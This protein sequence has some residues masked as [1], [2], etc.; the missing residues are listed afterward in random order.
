IGLGNWYGGKLADRSPR[1]R[2]VQAVLFLGGVLTLG[3]WFIVKCLG[4]GTIVSGLNLYPRIA[5]LSF[6]VCFPPAF[7]LSLPTPLAVKLIL[8]HVNQ[9]GRV[10]GLI[11]A[12]GTLGSL[13][14][15]FVTGFALIALFAVPVIVIGTSA[16]L[17]VLS[18]ALLLIGDVTTP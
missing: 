3:S 11:Y 2:T 6:L 17:V 5:V 13:I 4:I 12:L 14:G 16:S 15:N 7:V 10:V 9:T 1:V 18:L 8:P